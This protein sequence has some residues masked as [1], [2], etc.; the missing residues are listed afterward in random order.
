M[1]KN[2]NKNKNKTGNN[3]RNQGNSSS[4]TNN[5][6]CPNPRNRRPNKNRNKAGNFEVKDEAIKAN[7]PDCDQMDAGRSSGPVA[8]THNASEWY[9]NDG[10][11]S[12][13][14]KVNFSKALG[15]K[16]DLSAAG[17]EKFSNARMPGIM[18]LDT[19]SGIG[20]SGDNTSAVNI[21]AQEIYTKVR[22]CQS[23]ASTYGKQDL[24]MY[25]IMMSQ[26]LNLYRVG[27]RA[28]GLANY[29]NKVNRYMP[30]QFSDALGLDV[31]EISG[32]RNRFANILNH[33][34][35]QVAGYAIP[36]GLD[37]VKRNDFLY[38]N[39][40]MESTD[41]RS[42]IYLCRPAGYYTF[43]FGTGDTKVIRRKGAYLKWNPINYDKPMSIEEFKQLLNTVARTF[44][45]DE[46]WGNYSG[47]TM[48]TFPNYIMGWEPV[49]EQYF[50]EPIYDLD[51]LQSIRNATVFAPLEYGD[52]TQDPNI[53]KDYIL[54]TPRIP[55]TKSLID[56][57]INPYLGK[58]LI[59]LEYG[60]PT[61]AHGIAESTRLMAIP[62]VDPSDSNH[63][64]FN[65]ATP[66]D[67]VVGAHIYILEG[68]Q[69]A[70]LKKYDYMSVETV[71]LDDTSSWSSG[72]SNIRDRLYRMA[73]ANEFRYKPLQFVLVYR[74]NGSTG[75][76]VDSK[77]L[78]NSVLENYSV[79]DKTMLDELNST[80]MMSVFST[81]KLLA[82]KKA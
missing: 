25:Y 53:G 64:T 59:N 79:L 12:L 51:T 71:W 48:K 26:C 75:A 66:I 23:T 47:D 21:A 42:K 33:F 6:R 74:R 32:D 39:V 5:K 81:K 14:T 19:Y 65:A 37:F 9:D 31:E 20:F 3:N 34:A 30:W 57:K 27:C 10:L 80:C 24:M 63:F 17:Y 16:F 7:G 18:V 82:A 49:Y 70:E 22:N 46:D 54:S 58:R 4:N 68:D 73:V 77:V 38:S 15:E 36:E 2:K 52:I 11:L 78:L 41:P 35:K 62:V 29:I 55:A 56:A 40:F 8:P 45:G 61:D 72:F 69:R 28:L 76:V 44:V 1:A 67:I 60:Y 13:C 43:V 50:K